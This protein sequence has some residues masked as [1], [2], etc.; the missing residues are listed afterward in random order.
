MKKIS[1]HISYSEGVYSITANRLG[2]PN[3]PSDEH[4]ANMELLAEKVFEPLREHVGHPIKDLNLIKLLAEVT[5]H[6]TVKAKLWILTIVMV[7]LLM[8]ICMNG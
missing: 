4:L 7:T 5:R 2:L 8:L 3:D 1:K 6:N